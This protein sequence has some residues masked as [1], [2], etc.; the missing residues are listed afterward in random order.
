[1]AQTAAHEAGFSEACY[2]K[3]DGYC[4]G[5]YEV[6]DDSEENSEECICPCHVTHL[7][8][9]MDG[10]ERWHQIYWQMVNSEGE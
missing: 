8:A 6:E 1:M 2:E 5:F 4:D 9:T 10:V 3:G 7:P